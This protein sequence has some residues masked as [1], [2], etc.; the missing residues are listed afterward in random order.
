MSKTV[1]HNKSPS[2]DNKMEIMMMKRMNYI[3][4]NLDL[5]NPREM[6]QKI[7]LEAK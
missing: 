5:S 2:P 3:R 6:T 7:R 1:Q 4:N